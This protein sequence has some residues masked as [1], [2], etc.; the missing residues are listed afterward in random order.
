MTSITISVDDEIA[1]A[2]GTS[3]D[4]VERNVLESVILGL[5][6]RH[7]IAAGVAARALGMERFPFIAWAGE[8]GIPYFDYTDDE[9]EAEI[10]AI[11]QL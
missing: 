8:Q 1:S 2:L 4:Q 9:V 7:E 11:D 3:P 10:R 6:R 5:Y